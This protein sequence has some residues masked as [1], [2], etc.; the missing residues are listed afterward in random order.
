M[1]LDRNLC[2]FADDIVFFV[3]G[4]E[5]GA[6]RLERVEEGFSCDM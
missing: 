1:R 6:S 4:Q 2:G 3:R 5:V